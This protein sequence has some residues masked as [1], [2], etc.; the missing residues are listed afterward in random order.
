MLG[1]NNFLGPKNGI[2]FKCQ[3]CIVCYS[4]MCSIQMSGIQMYVIQMSVIQMSAIR[5]LPVISKS[6][7]TERKESNN[8]REQKVELRKIERNIE[9]KADTI[10]G[11][12]VW[13]FYNMT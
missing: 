1:K 2:A 5:F 10:K 6:K 8:R 9:R 4:D 12:G 7:Q 3:S 11:E 13:L